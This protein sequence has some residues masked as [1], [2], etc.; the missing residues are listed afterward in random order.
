MS[1]LHRCVYIACGT[2][3]VGLGVVGILLPLM[4]TTPFLLL[5]AFFYSRSSPRFLNW[6]LTNRW[7]GPYIR[8]YREGRGMPLRA[9][10]VTLSIMWL[11]M[12][13]TAYFLPEWWMRGL[14]LTVA[15]GV[16]AYVGFRLRTVPAS[17]ASAEAE[18]AAGAMGTAEVAS[19]V[20]GGPADIAPASDIS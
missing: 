15:L 14:L 6:L 7:F 4:P 20:I 5:A 12:G 17:E 18:A 8:H 11:T 3:C 10:I 9:K 19:V 1:R 2:V 16:T 13:L